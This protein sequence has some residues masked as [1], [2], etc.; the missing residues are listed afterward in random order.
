MGLVYSNRLD[1]HKIQKAPELRTENNYTLTLPG[2]EFLFDLK[3]FNMRIV[4][5][6]VILCV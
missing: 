6:S 1:L 5:L 4:K 3:E 2:K